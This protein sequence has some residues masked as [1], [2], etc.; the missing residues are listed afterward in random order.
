MLGCSVTDV[1]ARCGIDASEL[2]QWENGDG[3]PRLDA[4]Q[5]WAAAL[6]LHLLL[7]PAEKESRPGLRVDWPARRVTVDGNPIRLTPMEWKALERLARTPGQVVTHRAL[8]HHLYGEERDYRAQSTAI[9]VLITKLRRLLPL[10][11]EAQWGKGYVLTGL[12]SSQS[13]ADEG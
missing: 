13:D 3:V 8:F 10:R 2:T 12:A 1:G 4:V 6:G 7:T 11:I 5:R 9:R